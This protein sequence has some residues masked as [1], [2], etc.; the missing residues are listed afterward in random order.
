LK[1]WSKTLLYCYRYLENIVDT[2]DDMV[3]KISLYSVYYNR[4]T[5]TDTIS[6][7]NKVIE[8]NDRKVNLTN[9]KVVIEE[10]LNLLSCNDLQFVSLYYID[11]LT[12]EETAKVMGVSL[13]TF[14]R[15]RN[16][17]IDKLTNIL[18]DKYSVQYFF[19]N[20]IE[21][22][23]LIDLYKYYSKKEIEDNSSIEDCLDV[24]S[25]KLSN[26]KYIFETIK[27]LRKITV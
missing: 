2:I 19:D 7:I 11:G 9:L 14:F 27:E 21:E 22:T 3:K 12:A 15:R 5:N 20:Y 8:L 4:K 10:S 1:S 18:A 23:W 6:Q 24:A 13:R 25:K 26:G 16:K 17:A